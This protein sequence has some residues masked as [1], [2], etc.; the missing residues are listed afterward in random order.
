MNK[1]GRKITL[2]LIILCFSSLSCFA[3]DESPTND[4]SSAQALSG[5]QYAY[6][7]EGR[8]DPFKPF[9]SPKTSSASPD[10]NEIVDENIE[11]SGMQ[12]FEPGQLNLVGI[13]ATSRGFIAMVED[14]TKKGYML[15]AGD[16]IGKRGVV[17]LINEHEIIITETARTRGGQEMKETITM[18]I[19]R[20]G[21][22]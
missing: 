11:Y 12:L 6:N 3:R 15:K 16:L 20:E 4:N 1:A 8:S 22:K 14:Q 5:D 7:S 9:I 19:K 10:P 13:M 18:K 2:C 21:D 17:S